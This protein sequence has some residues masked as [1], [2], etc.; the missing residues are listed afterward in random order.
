MVI[1]MCRKTIVVVSSVALLLVAVIFAQPHISFYM[2]T[3]HFSPVHKIESLETSVAVKSWTTNGFLLLDGHTIRL[4]GLHSLP[5]ESPALT[6]IT[7]RGVEISADGRVY[8]LVRV[9][10]WCGNDPVRE[11][12]ARVNISDAMMFLH[13]GQTT[14]PIPEPDFTAREKGGRPRNAAEGRPPHSPYVA[15]GQG[16][17]PR[18]L[19]PHRRER[20]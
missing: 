3:G 20:R 12:I 16:G 13:I 4:P 1:V 15:R 18:H 10:H 6:E 9:H 7:K 8:G 14:S 19:S 5:G 11:H 2:L 17:G